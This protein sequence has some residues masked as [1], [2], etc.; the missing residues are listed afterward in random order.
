MRDRINRTIDYA[1]ISVT[2]R[3]NYKCNYCMP[4]GYTGSKTDKMSR[5]EIVNIAE[6]LAKLGIK[7]IKITGGEPLIRKDIVDII[8]DIKAIPEIEQVTI[9]TN[10]YLLERHLLRF[11]E[12][13]V[14]GINISI[15]AVDRE[16][17]KNITGFDEVDSVL[18]ALK[19]AIALKMKNIK[20][21]CVLI[22]GVNEVEYA[23]LAALAKEEDVCIKFIEMMP[24]G[25]GKENEVYTL[26][27]LHDCL[28][29]EFGE[30]H[31]LKKRYG[32]GPAIYYR[33]KEF[34]GKI[35][36][37]GAMTHKFCDKCNRIRITSDGFLK[38]CL[39][40]SG[41]VDLKPHLFKESMGELIER[42]VLNKKEEHKFGDELA[43]DIEN[44]FMSEI[45]G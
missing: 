6:N 9:T 8:A 34:K 16:L 3:C 28:S 12:I 11:S 31:E 33:P 24:I 40:Y 30:L 32:N 13:G 29:A 45:G 43:C 27:E 41:K 18:S 37:I 15:D 38:T 2:D 22:K 23:K 35:G 21:N 7:N 4:Q 17:Y 14:D 1:R 26:D 10:G 39:H 44:M 42:E 19:S 25:M 5:E 20:L 36:F